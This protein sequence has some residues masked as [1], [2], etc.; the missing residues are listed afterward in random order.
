MLR[1]F[2]CG[3]DTLSLAFF[4][5][6][7]NNLLMNIA[8]AVVMYGV[9]LELKIEDFKNAFIK[10][11]ALIVGLTSQF[12]FLPF[13]TLL[14]CMAIHPFITPTVALGMVL[15]AAC[16]GGNVSNYMTNLAKGNTGLSVSMT[17][18]STMLT[19]VMTPMNFFL[20]GKLITRFFNAQS[21][22][23]M[24]V[25][26]EIELMQLFTTIFIILGL[27]VFLGL[28]S[29]HYVPRVVKKILPIYKKLSML[30]LIAIIGVAIFQNLKYFAQ[31]ATVIFILVAIHNTIA[32]VT[33][34][35]LATVFKLSRYDRRAISIETAIQNGGL[36]LALLSN[37][38]IFP[39]ELPI[40]GIAFIAAGWGVWHIIGGMLVATFWSRRKIE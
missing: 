33:G 30:I 40:G 18:I 16:P 39:P 22:Q 21:A 17:T 13:I 29:R 8:I 15:I 1:E 9:A 10:P 14:F 11:K 26:L 36:A 4:D 32:F 24:V 7:G 6:A 34:F 12:I 38:K 2:F 31:Y 27:P 19:V 23:Q 3:L 37:P 35:S 25:P 5:K 20:Y 28:L